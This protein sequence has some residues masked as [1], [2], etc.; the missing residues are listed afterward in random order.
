VSNLIVETLNPWF[1]TGTIWLF[2][3]PLF[4]PC[5]LLHCQ[6]QLSSSIL[7]CRTNAYHSN[8]NSYAK[9]S[10]PYHKIVWDTKCCPKVRFS[11]RDWEWYTGR[12]KNCLFKFI[13]HAC[14][15][16]YKFVQ[17]ISWRSLWACGDEST[18]PAG[19]RRMRIKRPAPPCR[20]GWPSSNYYSI[21]WTH[22]SQFVV[23]W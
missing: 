5:C 19:I 6:Y 2:S 17:E 22:R 11:Q 8:S 23:P 15:I 20:D 1:A 10:C 18:N 9:A 12:V 4:P 7:H 14:I 16:S 13:W 3:F 21:S